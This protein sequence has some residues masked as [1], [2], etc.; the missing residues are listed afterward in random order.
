MPSPGI[1]VRIT[2]A[3][4]S[5]MTCVSPGQHSARWSVDNCYRDQAVTNARQL[6]DLLSSADASVVPPGA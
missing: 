3:E 2:F 4:R 5:T 1:D 6:A